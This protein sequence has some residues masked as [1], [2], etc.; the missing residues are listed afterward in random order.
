MQPT[1]IAASMAPATGV[2]RPATGAAAGQAAP[3]SDLLKSAVS[4]IDG[5]EQQAS[6]AIEG[7]LRG[8]GVDVHDAMIAAQKADMSFE[9]ALAVRNKAVAAYQQVMGMQF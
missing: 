9:L 6:T 5:L 3:F 2:L 4:G 8:T 1:A 7:L